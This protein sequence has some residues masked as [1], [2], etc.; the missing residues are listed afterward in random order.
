MKPR[1]PPRPHP[2]SRHQRG[3]SLIVSLVLLVL[4]TLI[5]VGS[6]RGVLLQTRMSGTTH[7]RSLAFQAAEAALREA[8]RRA[9][10]ATS[11]DFP[12]AGCASGYCATPAVADTPRW[13]DSAFA[14]WEPAAAAAPADAPTPEAIVEDMGDAPN[15]IGCENEIPRQPNCSTRRYRISAHSTAEGRASVLV[16]SQFAAP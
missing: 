8:E 12:G 10:T 4:V 6:M 3:I 5:A 1:R 13:M 14:G 15:W 7:D 2:S 9:A 16:Q 11:A